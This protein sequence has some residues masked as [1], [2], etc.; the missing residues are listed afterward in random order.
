MSALNSRVSHAASHL[1]L[2]GALARDALVASVTSAAERLA[3]LAQRA[4]EHVRSTEPGTLA[5]VGLSATALFL[6]H[7]RQ[8]RR[9]AEDAKLRVLR[10]LEGKLRSAADALTSLRELNASHAKAIAFLQAS[11]GAGMDDGVDSVCVGVLNGG[12]APV[13][14]DEDMLPDSATLP[15]VTS[16][17]ELSAG[18][19]PAGWDDRH[20]LWAM[21]ECTAPASS[22]GYELVAKSADCAVVFRKELEHGLYVYRREVAFAGVPASR[23]TAYIASCVESVASVQSLISTLAKIASSRAAVTIRAVEFRPAD[24]YALTHWRTQLG[25]FMSDRETVIV[26]RLIRSGLGDG[27]E[28]LEPGCV[29]HGLLLACSTHDERAPPDA[30]AVRVEHYTAQL[31]TATADG[32]GS[33][34]HGV[35]VMDL[36][37]FP[38]VI[39]RQAAKHLGEPSNQALARWVRE[40][41]SAHA[42]AGGG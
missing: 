26:E 39:I 8:V 14:E 15:P 1:G 33:K 17:F 29:P 9:A 18:G 40:W 35:Y 4:L 7:R 16:I 28:H 30:S 19:T 10:E 25:P 2:L 32:L 37:A 22:L 36:R 3:P 20:V 24:A 38:S 13:A 12:L 23:L 41:H 11:V 34:L 27:A 5:T 6:L 31:I 21:R 42:A